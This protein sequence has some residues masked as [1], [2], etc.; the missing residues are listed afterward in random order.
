VLK[1]YEIRN[2]TSIRPFNQIINKLE[3]F[4]EEPKITIYTDTSVYITGEAGCGIIVAAPEKEIEITA[5]L[6][7][8]DLKGATTGENVSVAL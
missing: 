4:K 5:K 2:Q 8:L 1:T 3:R 6:P 7:T